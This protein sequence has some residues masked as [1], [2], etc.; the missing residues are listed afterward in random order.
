MFGRQLRGVAYRHGLVMWRT[1]MSVLRVLLPFGLCTAVSLALFYVLK[2]ALDDIN[3]LPITFPS[4]GQR[5]NPKFAIVYDPTGQSQETTDLVNNL[6]NAMKQVWKQDTNTDTEAIRKNNISEFNE[7]IYNEQKDRSSLYLFNGL[8]IG[9]G[10]NSTHL[11]LTVLYNGT[12][13]NENMIQIQ[14]VLWKAFG[15]GDL[16]IRLVSFNV[17][18]STIVNTILPMMVLMGLNGLANLLTSMATGDVMSPQREY[19]LTCHLN[20][21]AFWLGCMIIDYA[22]WLVLSLVSCFIFFGIGDNMYRDNIGFS[23]WQCIVCGI[24]FT[25]FCYIISF[26]F[27]NV[28]TASGISSM[29]IVVLVLAAYVIDLLRGTKGDPYVTWIYGLFP[30]LTFFGSFSSLAKVIDP[31]SFGGAWKNK[32]TQSGL[33]MALVDIPL[34]MG[35]LWLAEKLKVAIPARRARSTFTGSADVF[36][37]IRN[38]Q[39]I[40]DEARQAAEE[41]LH[42]NPADYAI[43]ICQVSRAFRDANGAPIAAVNSVSMGIK[44]GALFGFLGANGA[45]KTTM[46][47]MITNEIPVSDGHI[48]VNGIDLAQTR[49]S[50]IAMCPQFND[51]LS[52]ELTVKEHIKFFGMLYGLDPGLVQTTSERFIEEL[53]LTEHQDKTVQELSGGNAR[54]LAIAVTLLSPANIVL[55][56][57]PTSSLDPVARHLVHSL[58]NHYR[59]Q[60]TFMLCTHLLGEAEALCDTISIMIKGSVFV[61]GTPQYLSSKFGTEWRVD[62]LLRDDSPGTTDSVRQYMQEHVPSATVVANR[63]RN[64]IYSVPASDVEIARLF[65]IMKDAV[66]QEVGVKYFTC[67]SSTLEKVF[68]EL[69]MRSE[70]VMAEPEPLSP[71]P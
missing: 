30:P 29:I 24:S 51:H 25:L 14:R 55:L 39:P 6:E 10:S 31:V 41:A 2:L 44:R 64:V 12:A 32:L 58:V 5:S 59:G 71:L 66:E 60:K 53:G 68:L 54:K 21:V 27:T 52:T 34:Y 3:P 4:S 46:M 57:E 26:F 50:G 48:E 69:V 49:V 47:K 22:I 38:Q 65:R 17:R 33:V 35:L 15:L 61:V 9:P 16:D 45:G 62:I 20:K 11:D 7:W 70:E 18:I 19:M 63:P 37:S 23:I 43:R 36:Q 28:D 13:G 56:D 67:S 1:K 8:E 40:T 42:G